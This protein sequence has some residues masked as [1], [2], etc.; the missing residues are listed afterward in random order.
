MAQLVMIFFFSKNTISTNSDRDV[1]IARSDWAGVKVK[2]K[3][4]ELLILISSLLAF[5]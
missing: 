3:T 1:C 5:A 2:V 4:I